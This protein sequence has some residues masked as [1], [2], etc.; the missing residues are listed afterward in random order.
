METRCIYLLLSQSLN[1][2]PLG[3]YRQEQDSHKQP[4]RVINRGSETAKSVYENATNRLGSNK[5]PEEFKVK[6]SSNAVLESRQE[7]IKIHY[8]DSIQKKLLNLNRSTC[9]KRASEISADNKDSLRS[10]YVHF[11]PNKVG[12]LN[13]NIE[14]RKRA[15]DRIKKADS[16]SPGQKK[17][18]L[19]K[20]DTFQLTKGRYTP[21]NLKRRTRVLAYQPTDPKEQFFKSVKEKR[22]NFKFYQNKL[23]E[24]V[25]RVEYK[26]KDK[27]LSHSVLIGSQNWDPKVAYVDSSSHQSISKRLTRSKERSRQKFPLKNLNNSVQHIAKE[28]PNASEYLD[29]Q[30]KRSFSAEGS[31]N[32]LCQ[33]KGCLEPFQNASTEPQK[34]KKRVVK[35]KKRRKRTKTRNIANPIDHRRNTFGSMTLQDLNYYERKYITKG[36][37]E[38]GP[39]S[40]SHYCKMAI[41]RLIR[42]Q[43][44]KNKGYTSIFEKRDHYKKLNATASKLHPPAR[45][46]STT[47]QIPN[48]LSLLGQ[49]S[50]FL[51]LLEINLWPSPP[52]PPNPQP[53]PSPKPPSR[54]N[55]LNST[56][57]TSL[58]SKPTKITKPMTNMTRL[59]SSVNKPRRNSR[60]LSEGK[61]TNYRRDDTDKYHFYE[62]NRE[63]KKSI[64]D[65][66]VYITPK[67]DVCYEKIK[68]SIMRL[69]I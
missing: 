2:K 48:P 37:S 24:K 68:C 65:V 3:E 34:R 25:H 19:D 53:R 63:E 46:P 22:K 32:I 8:K 26:I 66:D 52:T 9:S 69:E 17:L 49:A 61:D 20:L 13:P 10:D 41:S 67:Q 11:N 42:T 36:A 30:L 27:N 6:I 29:R 23:L 56:V 44:K 55:F 16:N 38:K 7:K 45:P 1:P 35:L 40:P 54:T 18:Q 15:S 59:Q 31:R 39:P 57:S 47:P 28:V 12:Y 60:V 14:K 62:E 43:W 33:K 64:A 5:P 21:G 58:C 51:T 50:P 4:K